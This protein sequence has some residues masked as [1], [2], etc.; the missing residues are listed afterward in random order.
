[1]SRP[2]LSVPKRLA[3]ATATV[4]LVGLVAEGVAR[5]APDDSTRSREDVLR[6]TLGDRTLSALSD[7]PGWDLD[8]DGG[9]NWRTTYTVNPWG[10]RGPDYENAGDQRV[11]FVGDSSIFGVALDWE[12]TFASRFEQVREKRLDVDVQ[13]GNCACPG[14]SSY[15]SVRK[16]E[17][18]C[19]GFEPD[20]VVIA[21]L[22]SDSTYA[23]MSD[24]E[25]WPTSLGSY[26][27]LFEWS[28]AYRLI[29]NPLL[30]RELAEVDQPAIIAQVGDEKDG[31]TRRVPVELYEEN[32]RKEIALVRDAGA[33][34]VFLMLPT[35]ADAGVN[36]KGFYWE[37]RDVMRALAES[38][39]IPL[40][41]GPEHYAQ[42]PYAEQGFIDHLHPSAL[43]AIE[44]AGLLDL[45]IPDPQ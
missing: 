15:Q 34:P 41:D 24:H 42:L 13:V 37:Y 35:I 25:R 18:Q 29:R 44:L 19:L 5:M 43:G 20:V 17:L 23:Q 38:E 28:A 40:A 12:E 14:H 21:N 32:L 39:G 27:G 22:Y 26:R 7:V 3:F 2:S 10:M 31:E 33:Q 11:I 4:L 9:A 16:L 6:D 8:P 36:A 30:E 1:M 45:A